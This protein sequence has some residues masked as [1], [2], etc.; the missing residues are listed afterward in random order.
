[1]RTALLVI[2]AALIS[3]CCCGNG[4]SKP[5]PATQQATLEP[6]TRPQLVEVTEYESNASSVLV[7]DPPITR[8]APRLDLARADRG[9]AAFVGYD[10]GVAE[11]FY[12]RVDDQQNYNNFGNWGAGFGTDD[13][14]Y[15]R[16]TVTETVGVRYR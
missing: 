16:R 12:R 3:G 13:S 1:M 5:V 6:A 8:G 11:Y 4:S 9:P 7:F 2:L 15:N 10:E 14:N